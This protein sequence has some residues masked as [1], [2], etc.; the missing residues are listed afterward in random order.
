[1]WEP[2]SEAESSG[3]PTAY[4]PTDCEGHQTCDEATAAT[5][6]KFFFTAV[7]IQIHLLDPKHLVEAGFL[8]SGQCGTSWNDYQ[9]VGASPGIDVLSVH[10]YYG[11]VPIGG[12]QWNGLAERF[13]QAKALDKPII[14]GEAGI[15]AGI[16]QSGCESLQQRALDMSAKMNAQFT[17]GS[18]AFLVWNWVVDPIGPCNYDTGPADTTLES[19]IA[20]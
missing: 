13:D 4:E 20:S 17:A 7:G 8:G 5:A 16:G 2:M 10:D 15:I 19:A 11:S 3:C 14:T 9:S 12:D 18:S 6:L 1:M